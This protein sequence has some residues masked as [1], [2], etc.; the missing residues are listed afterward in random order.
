MFGSIMGTLQTFVRD[1]NRGKEREMKKREIEKKIEQ[2]TEEEK[3]EAIKAKSQLFE[4]KRR[5]EREIK[6]LQVPQYSWLFTSRRVG[7]K[8]PC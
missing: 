2:R 6:A 3:E 8:I 7:L 1:E 4:E 5:K